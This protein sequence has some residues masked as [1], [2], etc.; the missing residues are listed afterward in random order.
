[1]E[2]GIKNCQLSTSEYCTGKN[3]AL[4]WQHVHL[5]RNLWLCGHLRCL[6]VWT[7]VNN[8]TIGCSSVQDEEQQ[9]V[10]MDEGSGRGPHNPYHV[11]SIDFHH[12]RRC[13]NSE[14]CLLVYSNQVRSKKQKEKDVTPEVSL[15]SVNTS[16]FPH[17]YHVWLR[18][19]YTIARAQNAENTGKIYFFALN[20]PVSPTCIF[21]RR[22]YSVSSRY[23]CDCH[24]RV[25]FKDEQS[26][27]KEN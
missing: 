8:Q 9:F 2:H 4:L 16:P 12:R 7:D 20:F 23:T 27:R 15:P 11:A 25:C 18:V 21:K 1:M 3:A 10:K 5:C 22:R 13:N 17:L 26:H 24:L 19:T 6:Q 14:D